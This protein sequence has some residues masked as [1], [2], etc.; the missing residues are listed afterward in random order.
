MTPAQ[1][2]AHYRNTRANPHANPASQLARRILEL[3]SINELH[4]EALANQQ[5]LQT[6]GVAPSDVR[7]TIRRRP[8]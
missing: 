7:V 8:R 1:Q 6:R 4:R 3:R 5:R 2:H